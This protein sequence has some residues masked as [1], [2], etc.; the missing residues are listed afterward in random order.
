M[1]SSTSDNPGVFLFSALLMA[2]FTLCDQNVQITVC[3]NFL[4]NFFYTLVKSISFIFSMLGTSDVFICITS[5]DVHYS[6][7][8]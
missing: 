3:L 8:N 6:K 7:G 4:I 1:K 2:T 5:V